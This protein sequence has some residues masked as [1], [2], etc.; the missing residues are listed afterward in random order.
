[1]R[2]TAARVLGVLAFWL[3]GAAV[4]QD[5]SYFVY[6]DRDVNAATGCTAT[7]PGGNI[8][9]AEIRVTANV[10]GTTVS[11]V[12]TA[13]CASGSF[14]SESPAGGPHPVGLNNGVSGAD[15]IEFSASRG[16]FGSA[17][18][19]RVALASENGT[20]ASSD[21]LLL[22]GSGG[23]IFLAL[24]RVAIPA[25]GGLGLLLLVG[26]LAFVA[27]RRLRLG[28]A[29]VGALL[30]AGAV[31]AAGYVTDGAVGDWAGVSPL[32]TDPNGDASGPDI[33]ADVVALFGPEENGR[34]F[35]RVDAV[36]VENQAP[37]AQA[38]SQ[39][40]LEDAAA[41][42]IVLTATD[43][44]GD[45]LTF[46][47]QTPPTRGT[48]SAITPIN[49]TSA[50]VTYTPNANEFGADSFTFV[51]N[52]SI[53][54][55]L[56]ATVSIT[57]TPVNDVPAF[58]AGPT[59]TIVKDIGAQTVNP[60]ATGI[61]AGPAN[62]SAQTL[63][64]TIT[65]NDNPAMFS[66]APAV[67][68][69]G[70]LT[71]TTAPNINGTAN[72]SLRVQD[73]GGTTNG[74]V[75]T[76]A[77]QNFIITA[78]PVNDAPSFTKGAD[79]TVLEDAGAQTVNPW[80]TAISAGP[81]DESGQT[82]TFN[83]TGNTNPALFSAG[84]TV[85][86]TG[87]LT[88]TPAADANGTATITLTLQDNG[89]TADGGA[90]TSAPQTFV[91]NVT[92]VNDAPAFTAG[93]TVTVVKDI[94][95]QTVDPWATGISAGPANES[96][97]TVSFTITAND[98]PGMFS[99]QPAVSPT[100][101]LSFTTAP[102]ANGSANLT[103]RLQD[104]GGTANGGFDT[105]ATQ[106]FTITLT[107]VN[108]APSFTKGADET[109]A[110]DAG[111]Q[112]VVPWATAISA[113]PA[114]ES[115]QTLTFNITGNTNA[116]LFSA[117]PA[118]SP[119][120]ALTYTPA[121]NANGTA[122]ITLTLQDNG[123]T[124]NGGV[125]T[126]APQT[127]VINVTAVNDA[128]VN[129][130]PAGPL[131][132]G[133][134][135]PLAFT[136]PNSIS[137]ADL[138]AAAG[139]VTTTVSTTLGS[140]TAT[141]Q[142][143]AIVTG[144]GSNSVSIT[145]IVADVNATLQTLS[146][147]SGA[148]GSGT[149]TVATSDNGNTG[150]GGPQ[151]DT[152]LIAINV[153]A[154]PAIIT[155]EAEIGGV[156][157]ALPPGPGQSTDANTDIRLIFSE[158]VT[159]TGNW[160]QVSCSISG[161][162]DVSSGLGVTDADP[163]YTLNPAV[164]FSPGD[165]CVLTVFASAINDDDL[166]DPPNNLA[167]DFVVAFNVDAAPA[168]TTTTPASGASNVAVNSNLVVNFSEPV[169]IGS[170]ATFSLECPNGSPIGFTVISPVT[171]PATT[172][173]VTIDP[174]GDLPI[175]SACTLTVFAALVGDSD[176]AD[177]P[178]TMLVDHVVNFT[179]TDPA[180][181]VTTT[182]PPNGGSASA[183]GNI[184]VNFS[185]N[186][187]FGLGSFTI[188]CGSAQTFT[189]SGT[190]TNQATLDPS[191]NLP[192][193]S[194]AV[195]V[196]GNQVT[197]TDA[198]DPPDTM[199]ANFNFSFTA[200][201]APPVLT[202]GA[203]LNFS[204]GSPAAVID[205][206]ITV[207]DPDTATLSSATAQ[208]TGGYINGEDVLSFTNTPNITGTFA[209]ATGTMTLSGTDTLANYQTALRSVRYNNT[210]DT[211]NTAAR[212]VSWIGNDGIANSVAVTSTINVSATDDGPTAVA[213]STT[214]VEDSG[215]TAVPVLG[216]DTD[217]D[218]GSISIS[219]VTQPANG[220][221]VITGGG[222][223]LTYAPN[224]NFCNTPPGTTLDTFTYTLT[225]GGSS[226]TVTVTVTCVDDNPTSVA[227]AA[228]VTEDSSANAINV[229]ANDTDVDG[230]S[231]SITSV[232]QPANGVVL[233]TGG[234]TGLTYQPNPN[235]CNNPPGTT[236]DTFTYTLT[237]GGST[238]TVT[239]TVTCV[240]DPPV[241]VADAATV[242]E[243]SGA[244]AVAVLTND[245]DPDAGPKSVASVTQPA[246]GVVVITGGGT[247]LTY[248]PNANY[249]NNPPGTTL[250]TFTYT[251]TPGG[252]STTVTMTVTCVNDAP[253]A[254]ADT[255]DFLGNTDLVVDLA[256]L[257]TPHAL[258]TTPSTF[259]VIDGDSDPIE[260]DSFS[261]SAIIVGACTDFSA[262]FDCSDP[263]VGRV[264]MQTNGRFQFTPAPGDA[265]ATETFQYMIT[266]TGTPLPAS[267]TATVTLTR[268]ER[269]WY[270]NAG[271]PGGGNGTASS[272]LNS[273][274]TLNGAGG[275]GDV[276]STGDYIFVHNSGSP[277]AGGLELE[278]NQRLLG[279]GVALSIPV[280]LN[281]NGSPT[282]LVAA[283]TRP[284]WNNSGGNTVSVSCAMP[285]EIRGL[286]LNST[287]GNAIDLTCAAALSGSAAL[288]IDRNDF[289]GASAEGVDLNLNASSTGALSLSFTNNA[290]IAGGTHTG[291]AF[292]L[293]NANAVTLVADVSNNSNIVSNAAG[294]V[295]NDTLVGGVTTITGF[296]NNTVSGNTGGAG[297]FVNNATFDTAAGG[298]FTTVSG[299]TTTVGV[300][301]NGVGTSGMVL[302]GVA[303]DLSFTDLDI[304]NDNGTG[305]R[306][307]SSGA[308][309][310]GTGTGFRLAVGSG[311][312]TVSSVG[313]PVIDFDSATIDLQSA[314][315]TGSGSTTQ[316]LRFNSARGTFSTNN[317]SSLSTSNAAATAFLSNGSAISSTF[318][319]PITV[320]AGKGVE[321]TSNAG[322]TFSFRGGL[323]FNTG[324][325]AAFL[326]TGGGTIEVCDENPCNAGA[327]GALVNTLTTTTA[328]ALNVTNT[329][330]S[331]N[332]LEF[333][334]INAGTG[335]GSAGA[336]IVLDGTGASG[337]LVVKGTGA[338]GS[339][340]T[341]Q[342]KTG[343]DEPAGATAGVYDP[344]GYGIFLRSTSNVSLRYMQLNDF[345]N[346]AIFGLSVSGFSLRDSVINGVI[347]TSSGPVEGPI[348]MGITNPGGLN[349]LQGTGLIRNTK[350]SGG[351][352][353]NLEFYN[354]SGAMD[355]TIDGTNPVSEGANPT[356]AADDV[357]DCA[358]GFNS[359]GSGSDGVQI[360]M[361]G[362]ATATIVVDRCLFRDN[363]SQPV[364]VAAN[365]NSIID[366][367]VDES[368]SR[369]LTQ[370]NEGILMSNGSNGRLTTHVTNS[371]FNN[372]GGTSLFVGQTAGNA[373]ALG[374]GVVGL[375][376][377]LRNNVI[378]APVTATNH[379]L[380]AFL[381][382]TTGQVS[383][384]NILI[385]ANTIAQ[386]STGGTA[387]PFLV[388]A[389]D[390]SRTPSWTA[391]VLTNNVTF[392]DAVTGATA[393]VS[394]RN[395]GDG[396][397]DVRN[398]VIAGPWGI[399]VRQATLA[400]ARLEQG[401][402]G[403]A[404]AAT[405][406][407]DNHVAGTL[408]SVAGTVTVVNNATCLTPPP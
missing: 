306:A 76:S 48:L 94:G 292:D 329:A 148:G 294:I 389:P 268:F 201:N 214:V 380:I 316:G 123:G 328:T 356:S 181:T 61:S 88:Y 43:G 359:A 378:N 107:P 60:W 57:L 238:A 394:A 393:D 403:S 344:F 118:V 91:I 236:L 219:A 355:L 311:V 296:A 35:F 156:F 364:Q 69:T 151:S 310:A 381:T 229:L 42:T 113:G 288:T 313:G 34:V 174:A 49:A 127:F 71:F 270:L 40:Y 223:G 205:N 180:P 111:A 282:N 376:A 209:P 26:A 377:V 222:T 58:T 191:A 140:F 285:N 276:D 258:E 408:T 87:A 185:E 369:N 90:D 84:P 404:V 108:D 274:S 264:Q 64:F 184:V 147:S 176:V 303:G 305:L 52:D 244:N 59:V 55:S 348:T 187:N 102:N 318:A 248:A 62:E 164:D 401:V 265:G 50:S 239:V 19:V 81:A 183:A 112:L 157:T 136:G 272:P 388:D 190:G 204:E 308:F 146:F 227:D 281:G 28:M 5:Y 256:A 299:G 254:D 45:P 73:D 301:G 387:R 402:S 249:C 232:T 278:A 330:I 161:I 405:A 346:S 210:S 309:N 343:A 2:R 198:I 370:G 251:L 106:N 332:N 86:P 257:A 78:T 63:T 125:D 14:G 263:A 226:T 261:V 179:T 312:G 68:P 175:T 246:N 366:L 207:T 141:A 259:G 54:N 247:G 152:D 186:V 53:V 375:N 211:P 121:A 159:T 39:T 128:P 362:T 129:T 13:T 30:V 101:A 383:L 385:E 302:T 231:I 144:S 336:G 339:G 134:G 235:Y 407:D 315:I 33:G 74:G 97:Q 352:E 221:V 320:T 105:S 124:A 44:D 252:S 400:T 194:C 206:T 192:L 18:V 347:G 117:A 154:A 267:T 218:G 119:T 130:V 172:T 89:G 250:D 173:S 178:N 4:A 398:N 158:P 36:D 351:I 317:G 298:A 99:V 397:F 21:L 120:G 384:A 51:A 391:S 72:L 171:L 406:L 253:V 9:G 358:I 271:A 234:G 255:F 149:I 188:N 109:V 23:P 116:A 295:I 163:V 390:A 365:D 96:A 155:A 8:D 354:Q 11:S 165:S 323:A 392:V 138:D 162:R 169:D 228:T 297:I 290:W 367:T 17:G 37:I 66:V 279:E 82:L 399:R 75:D 396:C 85:S 386:N 135:V 379:G 137:V 217:V 67:S 131:S 103:L 79:Q 286:S 372:F 291:N 114:D 29:S 47:I 65:A 133:V 25:L 166:I 319:G 3:A 361:Q 350:I 193:G 337:G 12:T 280:N 273:P 160:A 266:D 143:G 92:P 31:W 284:Q 7:Y 80:A 224:A 324:A 287:S 195:T 200:T 46:A 189:V 230:G 225:P 170:A 326:A 327:T 70:V 132:T 304:F 139:T 300:S 237:P 321:L 269:I 56:P 220:T 24:N 357:A 216:N 38:Q 213:D 20:A 345:D 241:A 360:E 325:N 277:L 374:G 100:G 245:T 177:P 353:H 199:A 340:G 289:R 342:H 203:T 373:N 77:V 293:V 208:I 215:A 168:V 240:D 197:D 275:A 95:A 15:V 145:D 368:F 307:T 202:A 262:P 27:S 142:N 349:G 98:N 153:D 395:G 41:Q 363:K 1:M 283:G 150:S 335:V 322:S 126:S 333:R 32:A 93:P 371:T 16:L 83:V 104:N 6:V 260:G 10:T 115:G 341:I 167:A 338:A 382:S 233:I 196:I 243:D 22:T 314:T 331:V 182:N 122:T 242:T 212:T 334:S 110:E